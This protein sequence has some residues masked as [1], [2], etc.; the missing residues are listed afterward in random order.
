MKQGPTD[1]IW[2]RGINSQS[3]IISLI[4]IE[5]EEGCFLNLH[6]EFIFFFVCLSSKQ[7]G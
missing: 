4:E 5:K 6:L 7:Y 2:I 1:K 3:R